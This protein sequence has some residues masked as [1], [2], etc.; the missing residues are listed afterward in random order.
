[1]KDNILKEKNFIS[2]VI[3]V[4]NDEELLSDTFELIYTQLNEN[5]EKY[6]IIFVNDDSTD[7]SVQVIEN[8]A[9][10]YNASCVSIINM[11]YFHGL[12]ACMSAGIDMSIGD[13]VFEFDCAYMD[14]P[15]EL[16]LEIYKKSLDGY[17]IV[18]AS[19][20]KVQKLSSKLFY[21]IFN[22]SV[23]MPYVLETESFR[24]LSRRAINRVN[25]MSKT[26]MY[27]KAIYANCGLKLLNVKYDAQQ[28]SANKT[29]KKSKKSK[30]DLA[31]NCFILYT[32]IAY[33]ITTIFTVIMM[34]IAL[35]AGIYAS[36]IFLTGNPIAGWTTLVLFLS[37]CFFALFAV[38]AIIVKYLSLIL[39]TAF[40][41][42]KYIFRSIEKISK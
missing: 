28:T 23:N 9:N 1:M 31:I 6:E 27:R 26:I 11:S 39:N 3:Y 21:K 34:C 7:C 20:N 37:V 30:I 36:L 15:K 16:L 25:S 4:H 10:K 5:F 29:D 13:F 24:I 33:R 35:G 42:Q 18:S 40:K 12:E 22:Y 38:L 19:S 32:D 8:N 17:D 2:A 41:E 14:F